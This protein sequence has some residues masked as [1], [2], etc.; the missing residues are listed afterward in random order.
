MTRF[1]RSLG[2]WLETGHVRFDLLHQTERAG[3]E[4]AVQLLTGHVFSKDAHSTALPPLQ[5]P[6]ETAID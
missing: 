5:H 4:P 3:F 2:S 6:A 1:S